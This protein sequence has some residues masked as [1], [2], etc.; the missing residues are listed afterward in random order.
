MHRDNNF[1]L[2]TSYPTQFSVSEITIIKE[3]TQ[4]DESNPDPYTLMMIKFLLL[5]PA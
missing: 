2:S 3:Q 4:S 5:S 1:F